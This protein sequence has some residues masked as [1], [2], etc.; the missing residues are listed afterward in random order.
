MNQKDFPNW[1]FV[2]KDGVT[3]AFKNL[4]SIEGFN[5]AV[6]VG[7]DGVCIFAKKG[8]SPSLYYMN[9]YEYATLQDFKGSN[10]LG[11]K[12]FEIG[13]WKRDGTLWFL[14]CI[15]DP[16]LVHE[17]YQELNAILLAFYRN[18]LKVG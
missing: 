7:P 5:I 18:Y 2:N 6:R 1:I 10:G 16:G 9:P 17:D 11:F 4:L 12:A 15:Y 13:G 8:I 14:D 3:F